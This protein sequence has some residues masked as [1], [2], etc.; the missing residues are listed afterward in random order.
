MIGIKITDFDVA[1]LNG[2]LPSLIDFLQNEIENN[3]QVNIVHQ[4]SGAPWDHIR[5]ISSLEELADFIRP[6][7]NR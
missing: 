4:F 1:S 2:V 7:V 5:T 6:Y 3:N